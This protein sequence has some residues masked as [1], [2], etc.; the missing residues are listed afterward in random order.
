MGGAA[1]QWLRDGLGLIRSSVGD[2]GA[3]GERARTRAASSSSR[4]HRPRRAALGPL[5]P[6]RP[7]RDHPRHDRRPHRPRRPRGDRLPGGRRARRHGGR[8]RRRARGAAGG[9]R[10]RGQRSPDAD[11]GRPRGRA[12]RPPHRQETTALGA[13]YLAGLAVGSLEGPRRDLASRWQVERTFEPAMDRGP[14]GGAAARAGRRAVERAK[15]WEVEGLEPRRH[16]RPLS[17]RSGLGR[18]RDRRR[19]DRPRAPR[20]RPRPAATGRSSSSS[21]DFAKGTSSRSTKLIHGGVRYLQQGNVS[22]GARGPARARTAA[23]QRP[24]PRPQ[25]RPSWSRAYDWW[26]GPFYGVG[27]KLY[28]LLAGRMGLGPVPLPLPR[29]DAGAHPHPGAR[30]AA[31]RRHLPRRPVRRRPA[32]RHP[33]AHARSDLGGV[34]LNYM[35]RGRPPQGGRAGA[36][37][38]WCGTRRPAT[39]ARSRPGWWSTPP[40]VFA[41]DLRRMDDPASRAAPRP[42]PGDPPGARPLVPARAT[43]AILVPHTD[44][45]RV[46][47][48]IPWH[49]RVI[50]GTTDTPVSERSLEPRA[51]PRGDRVPPHARRPLPHPRS[52]ARGRALLLRRPAPPG[53]RRP[54]RG[55]RRPPSR[56]TTRS[57]S[58]PRGW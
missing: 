10:R 1:V 19:R 9:R 49:G 55:R 24:P 14:A 58:P 53:A 27:L 37:R 26:E 23:A 34:A 30:G 17:T 6:R 2:R 52:R 25:P 42:E 46:L 57:S 16:A 4:L 35:R 15:G 5:R 48:A 33:A 11:P 45:G 47:F 18:P 21:S 3:G 7:R 38:P 44:D 50:V 36:R 32:R 40:G 31:R 8:L 54:G 56:A 29:G 22:P 51:L 28:D 39:S 12:G 41:D 43:S 20:S 13:A